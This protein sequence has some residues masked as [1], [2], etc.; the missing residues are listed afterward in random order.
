V[1]AGHPGGAAIERKRALAGRTE[2][3]DACHALLADLPDPAPTVPDVV[4]ADASDPQDRVPGCTWCSDTGVIETG[5]NDLPCEHCPA[6]RDAL[7]NSAFH[8]CPVR[9]DVLL[10][11]IAER[12]GHDESGCAVCV[13]RPS[14][15]RGEG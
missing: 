4:V 8:E 7:F 2:C 11:E 3:K 14:G 1:P 5:S 12:H 10:R 9:G 13:T 15:A 6:G